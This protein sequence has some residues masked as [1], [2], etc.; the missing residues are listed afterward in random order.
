MAGRVARGA[1][2]L[3]I[4]HPTVVDSREDDRAAAGRG[5]PLDLAGDLGRTARRDADLA[6]SR[7]PT[8]KS[9]A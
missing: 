4:E 3:H 8:V 6:H 7:I 5:K 1:Q 2:P 9:N